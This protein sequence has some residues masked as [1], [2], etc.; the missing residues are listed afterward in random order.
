MAEPTT[1]DLKTDILNKMGLSSSAEGSL[2]LGWL[3]KGY[4]DLNDRLRFYVASTTVSLT[5]TDPADYQLAITTSEILDVTIGTSLVKPRRVTREEILDMRRFNNAGVVPGDVYSYCIEG[6]LL[7]VYPTPSTTITLTIYYIGEP[8]QT[9]TAFA[10]TET[11]ST[12]LHMVPLG[13]L[14]DALEAYATWRAVEYDDKDVA[15]QN[16][17]QAR[18][19][20]LEAVQNA[21]VAL[22]KR[23]GRGLTGAKVGYPDKAG[24]PRRNDVYPTVS[25]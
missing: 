25:R 12:T 18:A 10:G 2:V 1:G 5:A 22:R 16:V 13:P 24:Y 6:N 3:L 4:R 9:S 14:S 21:R 11:L 20:Y 19:A 23:G 15:G 17:Q 7:Q 8:S